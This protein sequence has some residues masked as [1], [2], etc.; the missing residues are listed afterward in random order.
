MSISMTPS[1]LRPSSRDMDNVKNEAS[2]P[3]STSEA[4]HLRCTNEDDPANP[5]NWSNR[6]KWSVLLIACYVTFIV[7][8][9]A[10]AMTTASTAINDTFDISDAHFAK[11]Y[12][13]VVSW[14]VGAAIAPLF[15]LP[16]LEDCGIRI[17]YIVIYIVFV[18]FVIPQAV[19]Q[20]FATLIVCRFI[21]GCCGGVLQDVMDAI[22]ADLWPLAE[23]RSLPVSCY[24]L[25]LLG[26]VTLGP[27][28][29]GAVISGPG[30]RWIF[31]IQLM[32]YGASV[33]LVVAFIR[34]TRSNVILSRRRVQPG[35]GSK[36][37]AQSPKRSLKSVL[38]FLAS[39]IGRPVQ[40]LCTEPVVF[41]FTLLS[42]LSYGI[43]FISTQSVAQ[44]YPTLYN[45]QEYQAGLVQ[46]TLFV[47]ELLGFFATLYQNHI[48]AKAVQSNKTK[49]NSALPEVRLFLSI[50][51]SFI[52]LSGGLFWYGWAS[53]P[54]VHWIVPS[55]GLAFA[56]TGS[57][58]VM[59]AIMMYITDSYNEYAGSAS[60]AVCFGENIFAAFVPLASL[61]MY[62]NLG[63]HWASSLLAFIA[64]VLSFAPIA[65]ALKGKEI[66]KRSPF[67][68]SAATSLLSY[69]V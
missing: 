3:H 23:Q 17:G 28:Y 34:E 59:Q 50:P 15:V 41:F 36:I 39:N 24:V 13:P 67:M 37:T 7:G 26:G 58:V 32:L 64:L 6:T 2:S 20:N 46:T 61:P 35:G 18:L 60:A 16:I 47:G 52:G 22:I 44:V 57:M 49:R 21:A 10:T 31:Y 11:S 55:I 14:T 43:V 30:W 65:L 69:S 33:P 19:A 63:F 45:W 1:P 12:W 25:S 51:G 53:S 5:H 9:N 68:A 66:R 48:Y 40:L 42:A 54:D 62:T 8:L 56:G 4:S 27:V 29:G 38:S